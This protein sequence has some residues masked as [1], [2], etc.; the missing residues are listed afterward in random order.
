MVDVIGRGNDR[1]WVQGGKTAVNLLLLHDHL[2][3]A[4]DLLEET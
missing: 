4:V 3:V 1:G 2:F